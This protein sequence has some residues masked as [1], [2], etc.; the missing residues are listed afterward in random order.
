MHAVRTVCLSAGFVRLANVGVDLAFV[1]KA[2]SSRTDSRVHS[3]TTC[4]ETGQLIVG[5]TLSQF[6]LRQGRQ[7]PVYRDTRKPLREV[8]A[9]TLAI[10]F[11][12]QRQL[13]YTTLTIIKRDQDKR[14]SR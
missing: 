8:A 12:C 2:A 13:R 10:V 4:E 9:T 7:F 5:E 1:L 3:A 14:V 6:T 11:S